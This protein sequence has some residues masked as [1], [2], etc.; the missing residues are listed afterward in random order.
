[1]LGL[2]EILRGLDEKVDYVIE[3]RR[4]YYSCKDEYLQE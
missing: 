3:S 1:M 4:Y 2:Y